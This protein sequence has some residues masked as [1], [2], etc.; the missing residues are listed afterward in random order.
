MKQLRLKH[1][2][3][4]TILCLT[5]NVAISQQKTFLSGQDASTAVDWEFKITDGRNSGFWTTIPVPSNWETEGFGYY[6][7]GMDKME[8]R[9]APVGFYRHTFNY[10][11]Q[12]DKRYFITFQGSMTDTKVSL[13]GQD[14]G[15]H[16]GGYTEFKFEVSP[17]LSD[18]E[19]MLEVEVNS[20]STNASLVA[21]ELYADFWLFSG[22]FRPVFI[23]EVPDEFIEN[24][25]IDAQMTGDFKMWVYT[26]GV[27]KGQSLSGQLYDADHNKVGKPF[28]AELTDDKTE[29]LAHFDE[30]DLWSHEFPN[31]YSVEVA[32]KG[33]KEVL[34]TYTQKFGFRTFEVRDHDGFYLNGQ[35]ILLKSANMHSFRPETGR[36]LSMADMVENIRLMQEM[37]FNCVRPCHYPPDA[38]FFDLCDSLGLLSLDET[39]GWV[40]PLDVEIGTQIATEI[41]RRDVNHPSIILWGNGNHNA[42]VPELDPVFHKWDIQKRRPLKHAPK[43]GNIFKGYSPDWDIVNTTYY[44]NYATVK[45]CLFEEDHIYLPNET[46]HALYDGGGAANLKTFW[47]MFEASKVGGGLT[48]WALFDEGLMRTDMGYTADNQGAKAA[49]GIVGPHGEK[50]GSYYAIREI[51]SPVVI[52]NERIGADFNGTLEVHNKFSFTNLSDCKIE[53]KLINFAN[54]DGTPNGHRT[55]AS[56]LITSQIAAGD[57]GQLSLVLPDSYINNDALAIQVYDTKGMLVYDKRLPITTSQRPRFRASSNVP[58]KRLEGEAFSFQRYNTILNFDPNSGVLLS[59]LDKGKSTS[60]ANFPFLTYEE[61]DTA[62]ENSTVN[63]SP[64]S[65]T[66]E[67][68]NWIIEVENSRGFD[69]LK[70]TLKAN[71]EIALDYAYTL[72]KGKYYYAGIGMEVAAN[73]VLRKRFLGEGPERIWNNRT[74]GGILDVYAVEKQVNIPGSVYNTPAFEGCFAP[75]DWAVFYL[76]NH[77][78]IGFKNQT[79]VTLGVL[80]PTNA[81]DPKRATWHYP[82]TE[83]FFFF[84]YIASVGSKWKVAA[85]FGPD[86]QPHLIDKQVTCVVSMFI[87]WNKPI[88][89][90][91][92]VDMEVE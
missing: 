25:A 74:E 79:E 32:L 39:T 29:L 80:N 90:A 21:G 63:T 52:A 57:K 22:I 19:N 28:T 43:N 53:W 23:E 59:V 6:L 72:D 85:E 17:F 75:W 8:K 51:W 71:G 50:D 84:D 83:G 45:R 10:S 16:Q 78:N 41:V 88:V 11:T 58:Y 37:N 56:G 44:P 30:V 15:F 24:V 69:Y 76:D 89:K 35:R 49:D 9:T 67:G 62:L 38:Y 33:K 68:D 13:N 55:L 65:V 66:Q 77:L 27:E 82:K 18:G 92:R 46:L 4:L 3:L 91:K 2:L 26:N 47:D 34:H 70:W 42:H 36:T 40:R 54:P 73:D 12:K 31:L 7:Y 87:N 64:A 5:A 14:I 61:A 48:I 60:L 81:K 1:F 86:A 20:S